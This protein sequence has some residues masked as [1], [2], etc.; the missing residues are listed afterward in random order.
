MKGDHA[1]RAVG[2]KGEDIASEFL[3]SK[4]YEIIE[5]NHYTSHAELDII[6]LSPERD[7]VVFVEV[8]ARTRSVA[9]KYGRPAA[10]VGRQKQKNIIFA[11]EGYMRY[12]P[13][14]CSGRRV[15]IDVVEIFFEDGSPPLVN[16]IRSAVTAR[17]GYN[18]SW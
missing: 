4:G 3:R 2:N 7:T 13:D 10:A 5:R 14:I 12:H 9:D 8:K 17:R 16:H 6:A 11:A 18:R 1:S 15:R